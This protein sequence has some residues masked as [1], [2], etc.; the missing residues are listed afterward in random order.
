[1]DLESAVT[2]TGVLLLLGERFA[3]KVADAIEAKRR[4]SGDSLHR[5]FETTA[6]VV[7]ELHQL[8]AYLREQPNFHSLRLLS[9]HNSGEDLA[10]TMLWKSS[11]LTTMPTAH[12]EAE[13]W[14]EQPLDHEYFNH[15]LRPVVEQGSKITRTDELSPHS[16]LGAIYRKHEIRQCFSFLIKKTNNEIVYAVIAFRSDCRIPPHQ[17]NA[18]RV[19]QTESKKRFPHQ[20]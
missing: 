4:A 18:I 9:A 12:D 20:H 2:T 14:Q 6:G 17:V 5:A 3:K 1:M 19:C 13:Q 11:I 10:K 15:I 16:A 7:Q 8:Y